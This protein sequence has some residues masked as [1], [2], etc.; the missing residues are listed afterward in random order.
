M[1][2]VTEFASPAE[3]LGRE[4]VGQVRQLMQDLESAHAAA[5]AL[6]KN[7]GMAGRC[8]GCNARIYWVRHSSTT[9]RT[10]PY[11][12]DGTP[13]FGTCPD[14]DKFRRPKGAA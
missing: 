8:K 10:A 12:P 7:I 5:E 3:I 1:G 9:G 2:T 13:H 4:V 14:A 11:N 6:L